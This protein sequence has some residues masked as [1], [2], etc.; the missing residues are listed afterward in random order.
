[1]TLTPLLKVQ[2]LTIIPCYN[3]AN[4]CKSVIVDLLQFTDHIIAVNDG[5]TDSTDKVLHALLLEYPKKISVVS[6]HKNKGKGFA[7]IEGFRYAIDH[8]SFIALV[9]IDSDGQHRPCDIPGLINPIFHH[10]DL[11]IGERSFLSM[12]YKSKI[13]NSIITFLLRCVYFKAPKDTQ[14]GMRAFS[15][16]FVKTIIQE[17]VGGHYEMEMRCLLLALQQKRKIVSYPIPTIYIEKN[18]FSHFSVLRDSGKILKVLFFHI[19]HNKKK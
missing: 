6:F 10:H 12:P 4:F 18:K 19:F 2:T 7:L 16:D 8:F 11:V 5:S 13:A 17:I 9:T 15:Y 3:V 1:M 14:S